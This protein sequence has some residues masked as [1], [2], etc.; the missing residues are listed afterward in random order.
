MNTSSPPHYSVG[1]TKAHTKYSEKQQSGKY[2][3]KLLICL[4]WEIKKLS[5][6]NESGR[7]L[8]VDINGLVEGFRMCTVTGERRTFHA[9]LPASNRGW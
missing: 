3:E 2:Q 6:L 5:G 7:Q 1:I 8:L 9:I 4:A